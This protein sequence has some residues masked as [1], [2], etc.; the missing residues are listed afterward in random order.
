MSFFSG[1]G[2]VVVVVPPSFAVPLVRS[3]MS[4]SVAGVI[5]MG[6]KEPMRGLE[7]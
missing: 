4:G 1:D 3:S 2:G 6:S 7:M 5:L